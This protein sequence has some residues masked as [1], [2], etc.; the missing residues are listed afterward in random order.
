MRNLK[1][2]NLLGKVKSV[3]QYTFE[4][5]T[6]AGRVIKRKRADDLTFHYEMHSFYN[7]T[8][9][10]LHESSYN[11]DGKLVQKTIFNYNNERKPIEELIFDLNGIIH[12]TEFMY[13]DNGKEKGRRSYLQGNILY[14][15]LINIFDYN[16]KM[17]EVRGLNP[18]VDI[19]FTRTYKD[20]EKGNL[21]EFTECKVDGNFVEKHISKYDENNRE[22]ERIAMNTR[23]FDRIIT[24]YDEFHNEIEEIA[25]RDKE[26]IDLYRNFEYLFD[27]QKNWVQKKVFEQ[28]ESIEIIR[29]E[30]EYF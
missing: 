9:D 30:I 21:I 5:T 15:T 1:F 27:E 19:L 23:F 11:L 2:N 16:G 18:E 24:K 22:V 17:I 12:K 13:H 6:N 10:L 14:E 4:V 25:Y 8:G 3:K 26:V 28:G 29:R 20:D 7:E